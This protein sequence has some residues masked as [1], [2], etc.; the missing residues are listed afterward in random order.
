M[1][2]VLMPPAMRVDGEGLRSV[3]RRV[4]S[5][6]TVITVAEANGYRGITIGS[7][8]SVSLEPPLISFNVQRDAALHAYFLREGNRFAVNILGD[9]QGILSDR[10]AIPDRSGLLQFEGVGHHLDDTGLPLLD[11]SV[12]TLVCSVYACYPAGDHS[13]VLGEVETVHQGSATQPLLY[14]DRSYRTVSGR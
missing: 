13:L 14:Y 10:F 12:A 11:G 4:A 6:V 5:P 8:T 1:A 9:A 3:M 2:N 7:F